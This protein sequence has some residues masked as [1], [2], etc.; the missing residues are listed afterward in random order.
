MFDCVPVGALS[1]ITIPPREKL[2]RQSILLFVHNFVDV[3]AS[4]L[5]LFLHILVPI[6]DR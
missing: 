2:F 5:I 1:L 4:C 6:R 3:L